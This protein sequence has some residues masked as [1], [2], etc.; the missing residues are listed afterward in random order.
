MAEIPARGGTPRP[1]Q[2]TSPCGYPASTCRDRRSNVCSR[3]VSASCVAT[4]SSGSTP[5]RISPVIAP[6][7][8]TIPRTAVCS[9][10]GE[11]A[12]RSAVRSIRCAA[13]RTLIPSASPASISAR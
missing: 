3:V 9:I 11:I 5:A 10:Y 6:G 8:T 2:R 1:L 4:A 12:V 13:H 7:R